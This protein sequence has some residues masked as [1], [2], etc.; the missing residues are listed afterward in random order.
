MGGHELSELVPELIRVAEADI[1]VRKQHKSK[2]HL[3]S[4]G[5]I[6]FNGRGRR[7]WRNVRGGRCR[8]VAEDSDL[9]ADMDAGREDGDFH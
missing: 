1:R 4:I 2:A 9:N 3:V 7:R 8:A 6:R 5:I